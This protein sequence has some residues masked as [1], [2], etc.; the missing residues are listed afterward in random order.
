MKHFDLHPDQSPEELHVATGELL[1]HLE[2]QG[3]CPTCSAQILICAFGRTMMAIAEDEKHLAHML[4][5]FTS[6]TLAEFTRTNKR[7]T[8]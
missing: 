7:K 8:H 3:L 4:H 5:K 1:A 2:G 6:A